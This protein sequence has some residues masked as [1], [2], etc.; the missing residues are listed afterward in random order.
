MGNIIKR[1]T[2]NHPDFQALVKQLDHELWV[3]LEEDQGTYDHFNK[4]EDLRTAVVLYEENEPV[5]CGCFKRFDENSVEIKRMFVR[6]DKRGKGLSKKILSELETWAK[7]EK[8]ERAVLET[9][10]YFNTA[11]KLYF[12]SGYS[13][14][15]NYGPYADLPGSICMKKR[16]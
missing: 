8:Y 13:V 1:T 9:S 11:Q 7:E 16:L 14:I 15:P 6:K 2:A 10:I 12:G 3:E 4:V 5:G